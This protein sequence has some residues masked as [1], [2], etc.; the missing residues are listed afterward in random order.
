[1]RLIDPSNNALNLRIADL[2]SGER[3]M[4]SIALLL[5]QT[6]SRIQLAAIPKVLLLDEIDAPLHP[7]F[8][9]VLLET[10]KNTLVD[11]HGL[12]VIMATH[13]PSTVALAPP[14][15]V[16][17]LVREP[18]K[19]RQTSPSEACQIL[20]S[21]FVSITTT[22]VIVITES[23]ADPEYYGEVYS[24]LVRGGQLPSRPALKFIAASRKERDEQGGGS[25]QVHNWAPKLQELGLER[26]RGLVDRDQGQSETGVIKVLGRYSIENYIYDP[27]TLTA[28]LVHNGIVDILPG[29]N[30]ERQNVAELLR[31]GDR[32]L[33]QAVDQFCE[34]LSKESGETGI[35]ASSKVVANYL[36]RS[37]QISKWWIDV[38]GHDLETLLQK[39]LN[40]LAKK[41]RRSALVKSERRT[42]I[43]FQTKAFPELVPADFVSIFDGLQRLER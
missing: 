17:E 3:I 31:L 16:F 36:G 43:E 29:L 37:I 6:E 28:F 23:R 41:H 18:R 10:L 11:R 40:P 21:G 7:T 4:L 25:G 5:Y 14:E 15:S 42:L 13:S 26:F 9:R 39:F 35:S 24:S 19:L 38:K 20:S 34:W 27:L 33:E 1:L 32:N 8:T 2:S 12:K 30:L 22:D